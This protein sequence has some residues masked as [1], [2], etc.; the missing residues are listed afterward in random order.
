MFGS[1][2]TVIKTA[3]SVKLALITKAAEVANKV[4]FSNIPS[5]AFIPPWITTKIPTVNESS[6]SDELFMTLL[7]CI[8]RDGNRPQW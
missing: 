8:Q 6:N 2:R 4:L 5:L 7:F 3:I 1:S